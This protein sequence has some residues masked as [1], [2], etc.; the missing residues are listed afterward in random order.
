MTRLSGAE[1]LVEQLVR[2]R[3]P[4]LFGVCGHGNIGFLD[5]AHAASDRIKTISTHHEQAAGYMADAY[6]KV[7]HEPVATFTSSGPG[8]ANLPIA[9]AGAM[10]DSSAFLAI[11]GNVPTDQFNRGPFQETGR[12]FQADFPSVIRPYV[13]RSFQ[14]T[15]AEMV[16]LA[17]R[18]AMELMR[19]GTPGPVNIDVPFNVFVEETDQPLER[20]SE[21]ISNRAA[22][23]LAL[24]HQAAQALLAAE[25]P[26]ILA[27]QGVLLS[28]ASEVLQ[29][30]AEIVGAPIVT[31]P[32]GKTAANESHRLAAGVIGRN[33]TFAANEATKR[34]DVLLAVGCSFDD[35]TTSAWIDGYTFSPDS[36]K[37]IQ[38][39]VVP[40]EIGRNYPV[41]LGILGDA[42]ASLSEMIR[43]AESLT[44]GASGAPG[45]RHR[46]WLTE[47]EGYKQ[48]WDAY[49]EPLRTS[50]ANPV[51][52]ER[53]LHAIER[54][55]PDDGVF[56]VDVGAHHS[57]TLQMW[58]ARR[59]RGLLH[60]WGFEAMGYATA[61]ILGAKLA[62][63]DRPALALC[64]DGSFLTSAH[65]LATAVEYDIPVVWVVWNNYG[66][67]SI[68]HLQRGF[69]GGREIATS[70]VKERTG[71][72]YNPDFVALADAFGVSA[73]RVRRP[74]DLEDAIDQ[75]VKA[76]RPYLIEVEVDR[77]V[78][79]AYTGTWTLPPL[80]HPEGNFLERERNAGAS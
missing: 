80:P 59:P 24:L 57:W 66:Y 9:L 2:E 12:Y 35:R 18:Q 62:A 44:G 55:F 26:T 25:R 38:I 40:A 75:A 5:A 53:L 32:N 15:R 70:F 64:G 11:T 7:N 51:R 27:G 67:G 47:I 21:V 76:Q 79:A 34:A 63:P 8:S 49:Q 39:D 71:E 17:V 4:Y 73:A 78:T 20:P 16:P 61:G 37:I 14:P 23:D 19:S 13:K 45:E 56:A 31:S 42:R 46:A 72:F 36:T 28:E 65:A 69:F 3:V 6:Y 10:M 22:G 41:W 74:S 68:M 60:S 43:M 52:P 58:R 54:S 48:R 1:I 33:G 50:D 77:D 29:R 30:L